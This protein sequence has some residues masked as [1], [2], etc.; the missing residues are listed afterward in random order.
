MALVI[1]PGV[2]HTDHLP[3]EI[4]EYLLERFQDREA[5]FIET[6]QLPEH[7]P[8]VEDALYGPVNGDHPVVEEDVF[9][10]RR[11]GRETLSRMI[12]LPMR[13]TRKVT[14]IA[15]PYERDGQKWRCVLYTCYGGPLA[16]REVEPG[17][18][19]EQIQKSRAFWAE[20]ALAGYKR[21]E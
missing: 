1:L 20:H 15:G 5:F 4:L 9:Y 13:Y 7:L 2:S 16:E 17:M 21:S 10:V 6:F 14:V 12:N 8:E 19:E 11:P 3:K 18:T